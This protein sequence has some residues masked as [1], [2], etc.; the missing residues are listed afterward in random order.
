VGPQRY[1]DNQLVIPNRKQLLAAAWWRQPKIARLLLRTKRADVEALGERGF[2]AASY[3]YGNSRPNTEQTEFIEILASHS[4]SHFN[5][6]DR[7]GWTV[8]HRAAA[9]GTSADVKALLRMKVSMNHSTSR[10]NWSPIF[11]A[12]GYKNFDTLRALWDSHSDP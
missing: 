3:L 1:L 5:A 2:T 8:L 4:F 9:W 11:C 10:L 6:E 7:D 12:V